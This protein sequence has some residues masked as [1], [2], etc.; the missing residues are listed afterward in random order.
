M[1]IHG[2]TIDAGPCYVVAE[3]GLNHNGQM[4]TAHT[5]IEA[6][7]HA[8]ADAV[9][10][11]KRDPQACLTAAALAAPYTGRNS[12]G[13][14]YGAHRE[15]LELSQSQLAELRQHAAGADIHFFGSAFDIP[16][17]KVLVE[18]GVPAIKIPS[19]DLT[20][21]RLL[22]AAL[23]T[24]LPLIVSTGMATEVELDTAVDIL[25]PARAA[26]RLALLHCVSGYPVE[27][28]DAN[29][30]RMD[31]LMRYAVPVG[32]CL[33]PE[34]RI[35]RADLRW[36]KAAEVAVGDDLVAFDETL[37]QHNKMRRSRV[38]AIS[39]QALP[40]FRISTDKGV[41]VASADH[42]WVVSR[43]TGKVWPSGNRGGGWRRRWVTTDNLKIG[44]RL[45]HFVDPW[46]TDESKDA[47]WLAG[48][49]DGEGFWSGAKAGAHR[50]RRLCMAQNPGR[51]LDKTLRLLSAY[52]FRHHEWA[53]NKKRCRAVGL[54]GRRDTLR[55]LGMMRPDRFID[56]ADQ[57]WVGTRSWS[58]VS[59]GRV[60]SIEPIGLAPTV[61]ITTDT[62]TLIAEGFLSHNSGHEKGTAISVAAVARGACIIERHLTID[63]TMAGPDHAASLEPEGFRRLVRDIRKIEAALGPQAE[64]PLT[65]EMASK[66][67]LRK[68]AVAARPMAAGTVLGNFDVCYKS[69]EVEGAA[70]ADRK[71]WGKKLTRALKEDDPIMLADLI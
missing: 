22:E 37:D 9:K 44:D 50:G 31:W 2:R 53:P 59:V 56:A 67:K 70:A 33:A 57:I 64:Q 51:I 6:A 39:T 29:L 46:E 26:R 69:P 10:I 32:Y 8:G 48:I 11:Q 25:Q 17:L 3:L 1:K 40:S 38:T 62:G 55:F 66:R 63:R 68:C 36:C 24:D 20:H 19:C 16:S 23:A 47:G 15:A 54:G 14:T 52:G 49:F 65:C 5:L 30:R 28:Q 27:N 58:T 42:K 35:L 18:V 7:L 45:S 71:V 21:R 61:G 34:T 4:D 12:F 43:F 13:P 41:V 60:L